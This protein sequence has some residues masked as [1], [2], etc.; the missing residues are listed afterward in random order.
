MKIFKENSL[1]I[2]LFATGIGNSPQKNGYVSY[3]SAFSYH[4]V[5]TI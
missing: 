5:S 2:H 4:I 1:K 3:F